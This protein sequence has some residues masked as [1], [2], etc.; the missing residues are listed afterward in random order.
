MDLDHQCMFM[1]NDRQIVC[2]SHRLQHTWFGNK[3][4]KEIIHKNH[5]FSILRD[6]ITDKNII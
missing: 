4:I 6:F 5:L 3:E 2:Y 1:A